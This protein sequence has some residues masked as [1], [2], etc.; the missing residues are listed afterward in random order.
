MIVK[1]YAVIVTYCSKR[2]ALVL[3][4]LCPRK[5]GTLAPYSTTAVVQVCG[6]VHD[7]RSLRG[8]GPDRLPPPFTVHKIAIY[9]D[10]L[11]VVIKSCSIMIFE[12]YNNEREVDRKGS[13]TRS[14]AYGAAD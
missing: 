5:V 1:I 13:Y 9:T 12:W 2:W 7:A 4:E 8:Y 10:I 14:R 11:E 6:P 3:P